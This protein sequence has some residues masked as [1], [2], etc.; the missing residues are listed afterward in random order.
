MSR[1]PVIGALV[2]VSVLGAVLLFL[3]SPS[4]GPELVATKAQAPLPPRVEAAAAPSP[5]P[6]ARLPRKLDGEGAPIESIRPVGARGQVV[7]G[8]RGR[9][10]GARTRFSKEGRLRTDQAIEQAAE[11]RGWDEAMQQSVQDVVASTH[12]LGSGI[13]DAEESGTISRIEASRQLTLLQDAEREQLVALLGD[14]AKEFA[15]EVG[16]TGGA[17]VRGP[18]SAQRARRKAAVK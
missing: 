5:A 1:G 8:R 9:G 3:S 17:G 11:Q 16:L 14:D 15:V 7:A 4:T 2:G 13:L 10:V 18:V 12:E 6:S